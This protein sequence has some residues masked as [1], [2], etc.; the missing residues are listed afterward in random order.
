MTPSV[1]LFL[2]ILV[3]TGPIIIQ[4]GLSALDLYSPAF[5]QLTYIILLFSLS[6]VTLTEYEDLTGIL[7]GAV[8]PA[9]AATFLYTVA[10][11]KSDDP[12]A[13]K[14][15]QLVGF[16]LWTILVIFNVLRV[17]IDW[18]S[19]VTKSHANSDPIPNQ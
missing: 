5:P 2:R 18:L 19:S 10:I 9:L 13:C 11:L 16:Y 1:W 6:L 17:F 7:Y 14:N 12:S 4:Y 8:V 15:T 3:P